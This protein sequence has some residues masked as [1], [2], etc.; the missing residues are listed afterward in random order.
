LLTVEVLC[1]ALTTAVLG[2]TQLVNEAKA[3][4]WAVFGGGVSGKYG[5]AQND[6]WS[7]IRMQVSLP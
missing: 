1:T 6:I 3:L 7:R 2:K 4:G 5:S